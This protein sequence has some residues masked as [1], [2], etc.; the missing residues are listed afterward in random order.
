LVDQT[1]PLDP[2]AWAIVTGTIAL[3]CSLVAIVAAIVRNLW[4]KGDIG[5]GACWAL[6]VAVAGLFA[7]AKVNA[8][9]HIP[10][11]PA[12]TQEPS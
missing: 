6:A 7:L 10:D 3:L 4:T 2:Q 8:P 11:L 12:S 5:S 1:N 9:F